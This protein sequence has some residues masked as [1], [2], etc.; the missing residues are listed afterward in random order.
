QL[1]FQAVQVAAQF[2]GVVLQL[3]L[4]FIG[5]GAALVRVVLLGFFRLAA[6]LKLLPALADFLIDLGEP[7][8]HLAFDLLHALAMLLRFLG[9]LISF[10][11]QFLFRLL[12]LSQALIVAANLLL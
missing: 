10:L 2:F 9:D 3:G 12:Q 4:H 7:L 8:G 6:L 5:L 1:F 11:R